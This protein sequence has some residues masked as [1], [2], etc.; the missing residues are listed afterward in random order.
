MCP[1]HQFTYDVETTP[2]DFRESL[3]LKIAVC[4]G[5]RMTHYILTLILSNWYG[6]EQAV[7]IY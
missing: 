2:E 6:S 5:Y 4:V 7:E 1:S 3:M